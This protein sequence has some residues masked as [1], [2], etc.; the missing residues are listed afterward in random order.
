[1]AKFWKN[2][3]IINHLLQ[4]IFIFSSV[5]FAFWLTNRN[6][7]NKLKKLEQQAIE[8]VYLELHGN[9]TELE[10]AM[11]YHEELVDVLF[12]YTDSLSK[13]LKNISGENKPIHHLMQLLTR[14]ESAAGI[15]QL[16][17]SAWPTLQQS[18]A[19]ILLDYEVAST[20]SALYQLHEAG[21]TATV[22]Q[23]RV[24]VFATKDLFIP[25]QTEPI[26]NMAA[27]SFRELYGQEILLKKKTEEAMALLTEKY[28]I[29]K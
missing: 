22:H 6:E 9:L 2:T 26:L 23:L 27:W 16:K 25:G 8:G 4:F 3:L 12:S 7:T 21:V 14:K 29:K 17:S 5:Y 1:M 18:E 28:D 15:P 24:E 13:G 19:Y 10:K 20:L 11:P